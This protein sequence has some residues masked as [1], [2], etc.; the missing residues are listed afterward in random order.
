[1][2][3]EFYVYRMT[4]KRTK[5]MYFGR[6]SGPEHRFNCHIYALERGEHPNKYMQADF[7]SRKDWRLDILAGPMGRKEAN[8]L[9]RTTTIKYRDRAY[10]KTGVVPD[11]FQK[12]KGLTPEQIIEIRH[13]YASGEHTQT[14][15]AKMFGISQG[16]VSLTVSKLTHVNAGGPDKPRKISINNTRTHKYSE[17]QAEQVRQLIAQGKTYRQISDETGIM[18]WAIPRL[19]NGQYARSIKKTR[20][21]SL[22]RV[23]ENTNHGRLRLRF[24]GK[25]YKTLAEI[26]VASGGARLIKVD[27]EYFRLKKIDSEVNSNVST[28]EK[29]EH[30]VQ[31]LWCSK[32]RYTKRPILRLTVNE[33]IHGLKK[34][35]LKKYLKNVYCPPDIYFDEKIRMFRWKKEPV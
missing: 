19:A 15:I 35:S 5:K 27:D 16:M 20:T 25:L 4:N 24:E 32:N 1:M 6:S 7:K 30:A 10:N 17:E 23:S 18:M 21:V 2:K 3:K 13:L 11:N 28:L 12:R 22:K 33:W 14:E 34:G 26:R 9:E 8:E 31:N 29:L